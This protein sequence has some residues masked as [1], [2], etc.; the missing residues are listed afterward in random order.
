MDEPAPVLG[1][2]EGV[3]RGQALKGD[4]L[5]PADVHKAG[6]EDDGQWCTIV[7]QKHPDVVVEERAFAQL[8]AGVGYEEDKH[9][10]HDAQVEG[11]AV[12]E[13]GEHLDALLE[14]DEGDVEAE[15]VAGEA[16]DIAQPVARVGDGENPVHDEG[17][18][19]DPA[20]EGQVVDPGG[21]HDVVDGVVKDG[22]GPGHAHDDERLAGEQGEDDRAENRGQQHL[23]DTILRVR[24]GKHVQGE[25]Q[26]RQDAF[27]WHWSVSKVRKGQMEAM[28]CGL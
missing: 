19:A 8:T 26:G 2:E 13:Q 4:L 1:G 16:G 17:P 11:L 12:A 5:H 9:G 27:G 7:L 14:V 28:F 10:G 3:A 24:A 20:H 21:H 6:E 15:D 18:Q 25:G 23:I 22:D